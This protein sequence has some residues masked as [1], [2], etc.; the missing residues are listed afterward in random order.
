MAFQVGDPVVAGALRIVVA[1]APAMVVTV[2]IGRG[3]RRCRRDCGRGG[4]GFACVI[5]HMQF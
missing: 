2:G 4:R 5:C 1:R 3:V